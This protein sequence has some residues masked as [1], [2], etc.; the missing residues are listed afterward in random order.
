MAASLLEVVPVNVPLLLY[1]GSAAYDLS[2]GQLQFCREI[3]LDLWDTV[4]KAQALFPDLVVEVQ[5]VDAHYRFQENP[6][7][8]A[9][10][11]YNHCARGFAKPGM[12]LGPFLKFSL[13]GQFHDV[14]VSDIFTGT[15]EEIRRMDDAERLLSLIHI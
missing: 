13:Y 11:D 2:S 3:D 6:A 12:D 1:N 5:A 4:R 14:C 10:C 8:D 7:W 15:A 9:F